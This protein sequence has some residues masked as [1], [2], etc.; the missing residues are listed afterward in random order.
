MATSVYRVT[1]AAFDPGALLGAS[2][3]LP[4]G[5]RV[6]LRVAASSDAANVRA[7]LEA[8]HGEAAGLRA[9]RLLRFDPRRRL[10]LCA[11]ALVDGR[12]RLVGLGAIIL[13]G[14]SPRPDTLIVAADAPPGV[15]ELLEGAIVGRAEL[16]SRGRAA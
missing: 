11:A 2:Y 8:D 3:V 16:I 10:V 13:D 5:S 15:R 12:E 7:L 4:D 1:S 6:R 9:A 14:D